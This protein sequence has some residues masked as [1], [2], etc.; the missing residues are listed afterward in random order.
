MSSRVSGVFIFAWLATSLLW[1]QSPTGPA[2]PDLSQE[3]FVFDHLYET[4]RFDNDGSGV[5]ETT[6]VIRINSQAGVQAFGQLVFGYSTANEDLTID[7]VRIRKADGHVVDTPISTVQDFAP[8]VLRE[9]PMY[10]DYR[11]RHV[12]VVDLQ[13]AVTLEYHVIYRVK[14]LAPGEF[15]Y[16]YGFPRNWALSDGT[17]Q[18]E[19]PKARQVKLKSPERKYEAREEGD[20]Q[21]YVWSVKNFIP[22]RRNREDEEEDEDT[23][24]VQLSSFTDWQ[25]VS[26]WYAKLQSERAVPDENIKKKVAELTGGAASRE[27]KTR[28]LYSFVA[29][30]IRYVSLS[31]GVGRYQP[32]AASEVLQNGYGDCKDKHTLLQAMLA[33]EGIRS[34]PVLIHSGR[35]LDTD[36]PSPAQFNHVITAVKLGENFDWLDSTTEVAPYG[37]IAYPLRNK[38]AVVASSDSV[39]G[40][41]RTPAEVSVKS[42]TVLS[43]RAKV[44]EL[45]AL[46]A[47]VEMTATGD[48]DWPVRGIFRRLPEVNWPQALE[49]TSRAWGLPGDVSEVHIQAME[50]TA[51]PLHLNYHLHEADYFK[52]PNPGASFQLL[53]PMLGIRA[54]RTSKK[55]ASEP[56][57]VGPA[58]EQVYRVHVEFPPNFNVHDI[59]TDVR[60][61]R[62]YGEYSSSYKFSKN[63]LDAERH[64]I[65]R[66][67]ELPAMKRADYASFHNVVTSAV[68]Q[69]PGVALPR[70]RLRRSPRL[71]K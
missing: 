35:K 56:L 20:R 21:I 67:N 9:A 29:Q 52:V 69:T 11:Q 40:L 36:L 50:D 42:A 71:E 47:D 32:H 49:L 3:A 38:Q 1:A 34:Y 27:E 70:L 62:D 64:M 5:R 23:P 44:S 4:A 57:D 22:K 15:W 25:Q 14:P 6:A 68:E 61:A 30:N 46:D 43:V 59:P 18:I 39:A 19:V 45:G 54:P 28:R 65:L 31:F 2:N 41:R 24:D 63:I 66:V 58:G 7:Y 10:S 12:S 51:K 53:P 13:P 37:L 17:L 26:R 48:N 60:I 8:E 55:H 33:A 16:E